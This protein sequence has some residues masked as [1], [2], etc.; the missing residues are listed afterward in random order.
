MNRL[1]AL[2]CLA[3]AAL[4][5]SWRLCVHKCVIGVARIAAWAT[6]M[7]HR[8]RVAN[9]KEDLEIEEG[10]KGRR[11]CDLADVTLFERWIETPHGSGPLINVD[12]Y[13]ES[14][15]EVYVTHSERP[16]LTRAI[17]GGVLGRKIGGEGYGWKGALGAAAFAQKSTTSEVDNRAVYLHIET[18]EFSSVVECGAEAG[19]K[20]RDFAS[21]I[22]TQS[23]RFP[24]IQES[25]PLRRL[26]ARRHYETVIGE[27]E[28]AL[29]L[30]MDAV[31]AARANLI[32]ID[33]INMS[34]SN[35]HEYWTIVRRNKIE[36]ANN[37][38]EVTARKLAEPHR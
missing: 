20:A 1:V 34:R 16:T 32:H 27:A 9:A 7:K 5:F 35:L 17:V 2:G 26:Q 22:K 19:K 21:K 6:D 3:K 29:S 11:I 10:E 36:D 25:L 18:A 23:K 4:T 13:I 15:G 31:I 38:S 28:S 8:F 12:A 30:A 14:T 33:R 24:A 37:A